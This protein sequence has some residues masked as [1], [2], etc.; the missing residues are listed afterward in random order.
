MSDRRQRGAEQESPI[1]ERA[2]DRAY[3]ARFK[4]FA[5][6]SF[7]VDHATSVKVLLVILTVMGIQAYLTTPKESMP[8]VELPMIAV[9]TAYPG[10]SPADMETLVTRPLEDELSTIG[11]VKELSSTSTEGFSSVMAE[12]ETTVD[13]EDALARVREKVDLARP[14]LPP[15]AEDPSIVEFNFSEVPILQVNLSGEYGLVRLKEIA[16][17]LQDRLEAVPEI[18]RVDVRGGLEREVQVDVDLQKLKYY[19]LALTDVTDAVSRE[20]VNVPGGSIDVGRSKYLVR[21]D[22]EFD[23]PSV[24]EDLV[25]TNDW[26]RPVYV[27]DLATVDFGF[28]ERESYARLDGVDVVT[29]DV[30]KRSGRNIIQTSDAVKGVLAE[31]Q[32]LFPPTTVAKITSD[33]SEDIR[34]MVSSLENNI[35]SGLILIVGVLLFFLGLTN[36]FF[37]GISIP[38]SM[39][40]SF[41]VL[42]ALGTTMNMVVLFSLIL[43]LGMLVDNAIVVV[44]NIYRYMEEGWDRKLAAKKATGEVAMPVVAATLTTLAAFAPLLFW[45]GMTG[46]FMGYLPTTLIVTL[47]S[48]LFVAL[49]IVPSL[50]GSFMRLESG[51]RKGLTRVA[52]WTLMAAGVLALLVLVRVNPLTAGLLVL[53]ALLVWAL[54][55]FALTRFTHFFQARVVPAIVHTYEGQIRWALEHRGAIL[56]M[57]VLSFVVT[58][59][60]FGRFNHGVEFFP[61]DI[62]PKQ[63]FV[64]VETPVGTRADATNELVERLEAELRAVPGRSDWKSRVAAAGSGGGNAITGAMGQGGPSGPDRGRISL[65]FVD[66]QDQE[67]D[68]F[69][70]LAWMQDRVGND[71]AGAEVTVEGLQ[72]GVAG[73]PAVNVE[74]VGE[75]PDVLKRLSDEAILTLQNHP[76]FVRMVGLESDL[77]AARPELSVIVDREKAALYDLSTL[78]VG[79]AVRGAIQGVEA[80]KFRTGNDEFDIVVRLAPRYRQELDQLANLTVVAEGGQ[81]IPLSSVASW[82]VGEGYG[83]IRRKDQTRMA[84]VSADAAAG[85]N[86]NAL[87]VETRE[88]LAD[89]AASLPPGYT[90]QYTGQQ[91]D[92]AE[93]QEFLTSAFLV[94]LF[95]IGFILVSQFNSVVKPIIILTSVL[96]STVGVL[97]GLMIF[98]MPFGI[99]MTGVGI[100]SLAGIVVNNAIVL[101]DYID[102]LRTRDGM[103]RREALVQGG[104]TRF[105]PVV[106]TAATTALGLVPLAVGLN[107]DFFGLYA[108]LAPELYWGGEQAAWWG[109]MAVAV[110]AGIIFAT[111][112]TL[113]LVPVM[114]SLVDD[115]SEFFRRHFTHSGEDGV[116]GEGYTAAGGD[117]PESAE[118]GTESAPPARP[119]RKRK[120]V[121]ALRSSLSPGGGPELQPE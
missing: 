102:I 40:L 26:N 86:S 97:L 45:P 29:L 33:Q 92:Q 90:I 28:A 109:P 57:T 61:E 72:E 67:F 88:A 16:E 69:E 83:T 84:T 9:N 62:P 118:S 35:V 70:T 44:E 3:L 17:E 80:A 32:P 103:N 4:E 74:I 6:T 85:V 87:L 53:S 119:P 19:G 115:M 75:D 52:R 25:I 14:E 11:D 10:V 112:L 82:R 37:V 12:F 47:S 39:L 79:Q 55:H 7:A 116:V 99:I 68:V 58:A 76:V 111:F 51:P 93:A 63:V 96:M 107:F 81:Q 120:T 77:D 73:G 20:N 24:I 48:S 60:L 21:I 31:M 2:D 54:F 1:E 50:C 38:A 66:F 8:E 114:Y 100:I 59:A 104:K 101:I 34:K 113:V 49:V 56:G 94:A 41:V 65:S 22:G 42:K 27:R 108:S 18:L 30:I 15:D 95:L 78:D 89:F 98:R 5:P 36:S 91:E 110:I 46:E 71:I 23:D 64:D 117:D 106:L 105:R 43:A 13:L 121:A